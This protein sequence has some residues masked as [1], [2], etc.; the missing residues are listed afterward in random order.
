MQLC[1][2]FCFVTNA[3]T[4]NVPEGVNH[5]AVEPRSPYGHPVNTATQLSSLV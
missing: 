4:F 3:N 2:D 5:G 1:D